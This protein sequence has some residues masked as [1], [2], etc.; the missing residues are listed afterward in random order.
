MILLQALQARLNRINEKYKLW[1]FICGNIILH[2]SIFF[3]VIKAVVFF[4]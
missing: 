2:L 3:S 1:H 4:N